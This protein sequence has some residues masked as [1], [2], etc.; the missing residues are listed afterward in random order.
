LQL[1]HG[2]RPY[3]AVTSNGSATLPLLNGAIMDYNIAAR[4]AGQ[5]IVSTQFF[6]PPPPNVTDSACLA[7]KIEQ[8]FHGGSA[9]Y[10]VERC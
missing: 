7:A 3:L 6:L 2:R 8:R 1:D 9:A 10:P 4:V 5:G